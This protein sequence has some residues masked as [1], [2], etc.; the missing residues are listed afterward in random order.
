MVPDLFQVVLC[1]K[2]NVS[3][4]VHG[5]AAKTVHAR[6][7]KQRTTDSEHASQLANMLQ[8]SGSRLT[9]SYSHAAVQ[10]AAYKGARHAAQC[11][12]N[13]IT[14]LPHVL[15]VHVT[16]C[17]QNVRAQVFVSFCTWTAGW[18]AT[19]HPGST[20]FFALLVTV[21]AQLLANLLAHTATNNVLLKTGAPGR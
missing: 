4:P 13:Q 21:I 15:F 6:A 7:S 8:C 3:R 9:T 5:A 12:L 10:H 2:T 20:P 19:W 17:T 16:R 11:N 18:A 1:T 14:A